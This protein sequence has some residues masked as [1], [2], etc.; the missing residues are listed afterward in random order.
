MKKAGRKP[1]LF[2]VYKAGQFRISFCL[3]TDKHMKKQ[4]VLLS[5]AAVFAT[6]SFSLFADDAPTKASP[7]VASAM[8]TVGGKQ[9]RVVATHQSRAV[10]Y[11]T[12]QV[13]TGSNIPV[14]VTRYQGHNTTSSP[15]VNYDQ[16]QLST[17][18]ALNVGGAL[19]TVDPA[20]TFGR[21]R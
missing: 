13:V 5:L 17:T 1:G 19:K 9:A 21:A 2:F 12:N 16:T 14:V 6:P 10:F 8:R 7:S 4:L 18:G 20:I 11:I 3:S 15:L